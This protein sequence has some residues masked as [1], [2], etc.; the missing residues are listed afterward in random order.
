MTY[1]KGGSQVACGKDWPAMQVSIGGLGLILCW[2]N[3]LEEMATRSSIS[4]IENSMDRG[5]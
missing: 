5:V 1:G 2:E 3:R 4:A